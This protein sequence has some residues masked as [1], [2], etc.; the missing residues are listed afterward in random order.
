MNKTNK[1]Y[2]NEEILYNF[3]FE[4]SYLTIGKLIENITT[5]VENEC[6][7]ENNESEEDLIKDL[8]N[9]IFLQD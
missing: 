3:K 4:S 6:T 5:F 8:I 1:Y 2:W 9:Q 7:F